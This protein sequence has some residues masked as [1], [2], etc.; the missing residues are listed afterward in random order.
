MTAGR[1]RVGRHARDHLRRG[2]RD[3]RYADGRND[4]D[5]H[6]R[7]LARSRKSASTAS[8]RPGNRQRA[9]G[10]NFEIIG[11]FSATSLRP[12]TITIDG[13]AGDDTIDISSLDSAHRIVFRS[14]GGNDTIIGT[15]RAQD[16]IELPAGAVAADYQTTTVNGVTTM[17]GPGGHTIT[18]TAAAGETPQVGGEAGEGE[19]TEGPDEEVTTPPPGTP[20]TPV[21]GVVKMGTAQDDTLAGTADADVLTGEAGKDYLSGE[22]GNDIVFAGEGNDDVFG[23]AGDDM[24][25]GDAGADRVF[26]GDG[27]D[28][29]T[30]GAGND[31]VLRRLRQRPDRGRSW[32]TA[33]TPTLATT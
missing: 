16:V 21:A 19:E 11:D 30:A 3:R 8:I 32:L 26:G 23:G 17:T 20:T 2:H 14:N 22:G 6:R 27:Q 24:L 1:T 4:D 31:T 25:Y 10:D 33:T 9:G 15:L 12:N 28:F 18:F 7:A 29:I 13:D 5:R